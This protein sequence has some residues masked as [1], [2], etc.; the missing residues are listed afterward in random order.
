MDE[1]LDFVYN[2]GYYVVCFLVCIAVGLYMFQNKMLYM[3]MMPN[4]PFKTP[5]DNPEMFKNPGEHGID[6]QDIYI[7][8]SDNETLHAWFLKQ[9]N[10]RQ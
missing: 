1:I 7:K 4:V 8:T 5:D 10:H 6:Y 3:P 9:P 2:A